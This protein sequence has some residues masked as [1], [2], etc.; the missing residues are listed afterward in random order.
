MTSTRWPGAGARRAMIGLAAALALATGSVATPVQAQTET[1]GERLSDISQLITAASFAAGTAFALG[2]ILK[3]QV[4][5]D[6]PTQ[7][8]VG[9]AIAALSNAFSCPT[10][11]GSGVL[12]GEGTCVWTKV[13]GT[14]GSQYPMSS[15]AVDWHVGGQFEVGP[16]WFVGGV[17]GAGGSSWQILSGPSSNGQTIDG[18]LVLKRVVGPYFLAVGVGLSNTTNRYNWP[19]ATTNGIVNMT[20]SSSAFSGGVRL[21]GA[22]EVELG[23]VYLR[24]RADFDVGLVTQS[25]LAESGPAPALRVDASSKAGIALTPALEIGGRYDVGPATILRPYASAA[26]TYLPDSSVP[27]SGSIGGTSFAGT[28]YGPNVITTIEAGLQLYEIKAWELKAEYRLITAG[29][30]LSQSAGLRAAKHF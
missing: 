20:S 16:G 23:S 19:V 22:Y 18:A 2:A 5:P 24:P 26:V 1:P 7:I 25:G 11:V 30:F 17:L 28:L 27:V 21:R 14:W 10:F 4:H 13:A 9:E 15:S 12:L 6:N 8:P 29:A 3:F